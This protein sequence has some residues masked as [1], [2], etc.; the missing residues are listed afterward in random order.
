[1]EE[2]VNKS[3]FKKDELSQQPEMPNIPDMSTIPP[4][5][6]ISGN[7]NNADSG[8]TP[9]PVFDTPDLNAAEERT[10]IVENNI[11]SEKPEQNYF[12]QNNY[13]VSNHPQTNTDST[14]VNNA[15]N[16]NANF[17][18]ENKNLSTGPQNQPNYNQGYG[19]QRT[20]NP[21]F[22]PKKSVPNSAGVLT[23]GILSILS[24]C[25][26]GGFL[27]PILSIIA[28]ALIP[29]ARK[30]YSQNPDLYS[31]SSMGSLKAGKICAIIGLVLAIIF[32]I[33]L[34]V[35]MAVQGHDANYFNEAINEAW[36]ESGY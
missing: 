32:I 34:I 11:T 16:N 28:L 22:F 13:S 3:D 33:Y 6:D 5:P 26:C 30:A 12:T 4:L 9:P 21:S 8:I 24:L 20:A 25:C 14:T 17:G 10:V 29:K 36:N 27:A 7:S 1:M 2:N 23:L 31:T 15:P 35:A 19:N 18:F